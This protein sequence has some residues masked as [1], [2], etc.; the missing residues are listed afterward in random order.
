M[1]PKIQSSEVKNRNTKDITRDLNHGIEKSQSFKG[2]G[3]L[4]LQ[5]VQLCERHP[6]V[7]VSV[8]DFSTAIIP[9]TVI[10]TYSGDAVV[11]E[12]GEKKRK[13][14][15]FAGMEAFRREAS[16]LVINCLI[17]GFIVAGVAKLVQNPIM[18]G[19]KTDLSRS[20]ANSDSLDKISKYI[21]GTMLA[22]LVIF[23]LSYLYYWG[24]KYEIIC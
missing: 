8:L 10:E 12:K 5:G 17:P 4:V 11:N 14:N 2:V 15:F 6:M 18:K 22:V 1:I 21:F 20:W 19:F 13:A 9:R 3:D 24:V 23:V 7:N 16:G